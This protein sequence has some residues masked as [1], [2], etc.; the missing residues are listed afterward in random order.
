[1]EK[2]KRWQWLVLLTSFFQLLSPPIL[3]VLGL[4]VNGQNAG[5]AQGGDPQLTPAGYTFIVWGVITLLSFSYGIYQS[6]PDRRNQP[7]HKT[8]SSRLAM[9]YL[10]FVCWLVAAVLQWLAMTVF[11]FLAM[12]VL[13]TGVFNVVLAERSRLNLTEKIILFGQLAVYT[14]WTT[15][16]IFANTASAIKFYGVSDKGTTGI[17]WQAVILTFALLN[18]KYW[19]KKFN[20][21]LVFGATIIWA[22]VGIFFG[23]LQYDD[24]LV[25]RLI[26][27]FGILLVGGHI[28]VKLV[29][30]QMK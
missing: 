5:N 26:T 19:L 9:I 14:G 10:L 2:V 11:I 16:A 4:S 23:L 22:L 20:L 30:P 25:L 12:F 21:D 3:T 15:V 27:I 6:L 1:M 13:L 17:I 29:R 8:L 28:I 18:G 24:N 7:L